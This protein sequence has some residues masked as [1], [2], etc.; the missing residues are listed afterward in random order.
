M[1]R[2][3]Q[4]EGGRRAEGVCD[5]WGV[6]GGEGVEGGAG[7]GRGRMGRGWE[8]GVAKCITRAMM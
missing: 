4:R 8:R 5:E 3:A 1:G 2:A 7:R 6:G